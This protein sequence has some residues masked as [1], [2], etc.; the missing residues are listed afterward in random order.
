MGLLDFFKRKS[1][2]EIERERREK[3]LRHGRIADGTILDCQSTEQGEVVYYTYSVHGADFESSQLLTET[4]RRELLKYAPGAH[5][6]IRFDP[7]Q[8]ANSIVE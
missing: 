2:A 4:Q 3:L 7:R 1:A 6:G 8:H 5:V